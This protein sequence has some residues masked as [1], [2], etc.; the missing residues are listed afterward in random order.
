MNARVIKICR[1]GENYK[2]KARQVEKFRLHI[3][4]HGAQSLNRACGIQ[5]RTPLTLRRA[6]SRPVEGEPELGVFLA[7]IDPVL[8]GVDSQLMNS[9]QDRIP[10][11][12][13]TLLSIWI[14]IFIIMRAGFPG[15]SV[16]KEST[17]NAGDPGSIPELGTSLGEGNCNPL[18]YPCLENPWTE[19]PGGL[20]SI[21]SQESDMTEWL[22]HTTSEGVIHCFVTRG[23]FFQDLIC[24]YHCLIRHCFDVL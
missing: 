18:Q 2:E 11:L 23:I 4:L 15:G 20:Q 5:A 19:E 21:A 12:D 10:S 16:G 9:L 14:Y 22:S 13:M 1:N 24:L 8:T 17:C 6:A 3:L 7:L